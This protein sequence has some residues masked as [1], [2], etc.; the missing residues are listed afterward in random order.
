MKTLEKIFSFYY[1]FKLRT[2]LL[3]TLLMVGVVSIGVIGL[4][5]YFAGK[6][7][8]SI[9][10]FSKLTAVREIRGKVIEDYFGTIRKQV[11]TLSSNQMVIDAMKE[12]KS[13]YSNVFRVNN[14][15]DND[16]NNYKSSLTGYYQNE[17][18]PRLD[19]NLNSRSNVSEFFP[20]DQT[21]LYLQYLYISNNS[22]AVGS[23]DGLD[24][25]Q[26]R[27][28]YSQSHEKYHPQFR[29][30][31]QVFGYY[32]IFLID[33]VTG[34]IVY[35]VYKELD[36]ATSLISGPYANTNFGKLFKEVRNSSNKDDSKLMDFD[37]YKPSYGAAASFM[38]SPIFD[39][40]QRIGVLIFQMPLD[41][42]NGVMTGNG[43]WKTEGLGDSGESYLVGDDYKMRSNSRFLIEDEENYFAAIKKLGTDQQTMDRIKSFGSTILYQKIETEGV[44]NALSG[45]SGSKIIKDYRDVSVLSSYKPLNIKDVN[46][47]LLSEIDEAEAFAPIYALRNSILFWGAII[48]FFVIII[49]LG[50]TE[51]I[52]TPIK[53]IV[54]LTKKLGEGDL[55]DSIDIKSKDEMGE[56]ATDLNV[57]VKN[58]HN[59]ISELSNTTVK[60][61]ESSDDLQS[62]STEMSS[63]A[64]EMNSQSSAVASA[65][66]QISANVSTV[67]SA[68]EE[69]TSVISNIAAITEEMSSTFQNVAQNTDV[70]AEKVEEMATM[71]QDMS[72]AVNSVATAVEEMSASFNEVSIRTN[73]AN[74]I[75][76]AASEKISQ[77]NKKMENLVESSKEIGKVIDVIKDIADQTNMLALNATIEAAGAGEAGKGF[78]VVAGE[79]KELAKQ[80]AEATEVIS[81]QISN[82]QESTNDAVSSV[83]EINEIILEIA[84]ISKT[85]V[86]S[87][88]EQKST[89]NEISSTMAT[90]ASLA[91]GVAE[92]AGTVSNLVSDISKSILEATKTATEVAKNVDDAAS[93][94][95]EI[96]R[97]SN[98]ASLGVQEISKNIQNI[99]IASAQ[100]AEGANKTNLSAKGLAELS[101]VIGNIVSKFKI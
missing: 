91:K 7:A 61:T 14:I 38:A 90:N 27:S 99:N 20:T 29:Q 59:L 35:S 66:E 41:E 34:D 64:E 80:S 88:D 69:S 24:F 3:A 49:A 68:A 21:S 84:E 95:K 60:M 40:N 89:T 44:L 22:N 25:A 18:I 75:S 67:A 30:F 57:S 82:I 83:G 26:E 47:V 10:S 94:V 15:S 37:F 51:T 101:S 92:N 19:A 100:T 43:N 76:E 55:T 87:I 39:G 23:K 74:D 6:N 2:K 32:D 13:G 46:W 36:Y 62:V 71:G 52:M 78:A 63:S 73:K 53:E 56:M 70:T 11:I 50:F 98:E 65:T 8:I 54:K 81:G 4:N 33:D 5:G 85:I 31:L 42:I 72:E 97:S 77:I 28:S 12:F 1:N 93:G 9:E 58:L 45:K 48:L 86:Q 17:F 16:L 79:V 96:A